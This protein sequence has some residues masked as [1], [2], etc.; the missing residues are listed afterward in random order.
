MWSC[1]QFWMERMIEDRGY[2]SLGISPDGTYVAPME[3]SPEQNDHS[4]EDGTAHAQQ[5]IYSLLKS[6]RES[7]DILPAASTG[8][9]QAQLERLDDYLARTDRGLHTEIYTANIVAD[10]AWTN[11]RHGVYKGDTLLREWKY[12][13]YDVSHDASH[14]HSSH[15]MALYPLSEIGPDSPYFMPAV[16]SLRL[17][18]DEST[19]WS[20]G[21]KV[22]LW[23]RAL[24]GDHAHRIIRNALKHSTSYD[25]DQYAGGIY[26]N[27][28]DSHAPFQIDGNFGVCAG[29]AE[30]LMQSHTD[31]I[32][33]LPALPTAWTEGSV[34]G[35][36]AVG[37]FQ[38]DIDWS[39]G[40]LSKA[41]IR[42]DSGQ[43][44]PV[45]YPGIAGR[46][47]TDGKGRE[48]SVTRVSDD[49][50]L[51]PT[52]QGETYMIDM[53]RDA[54]RQNF[55]EDERGR[56]EVYSL[57]GIINVEGKG[58]TVTLSDSNAETAAGKSASSYIIHDSDLRTIVNE[59]RSADAEAISIN[60]ERLIA[61]SEIRCVGPTIIINGNKYVPP[62]NIK[63]IG[64]PDM[65]EAAL[66]LKGGIID[67]LKSLYGFDIV[68]SKSANLKIEKYSGI[69][70]F[71][72]AKPAE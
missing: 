49:L 67:Q 71:K 29:V 52:T 61:S 25:V 15:L 40:K 48:V 43:P 1:A 7:I 30:M 60:G 20:M 47:V 24:D 31:I 38:V 45:R 64:D 12:S 28:Y 68:I 10:S 26:Y 32:A 66:K 14:R 63:A 6:V 51:V 16:R 58:I 35:L 70:S 41:A 56:Y 72:Y 65:L 23:A 33:L 13:A 34:C 21:W 17:R 5:L 54:T 9:T 57:G 19:G 69:V 39:A 11:P 59:L 36:R 50:V 53:N 3:Y 27:L 37:N 42:S 22:N 8:L 18:G 55:D 2:E 62:F 4:H 46:L 44:C